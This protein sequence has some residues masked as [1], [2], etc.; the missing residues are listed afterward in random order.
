M[1]GTPLPESEYRSTG[2]EEDEEDEVSPAV[3]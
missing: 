3:E 2:D 1:I